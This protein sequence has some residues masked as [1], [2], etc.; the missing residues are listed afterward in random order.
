MG[1]EVI[2]VETVGVGQDEVEIVNT[3]HTSIVVLVPGMGDD[4]QAIKAGIIEIGDLF[5]INKSDREGERKRWER[6]SGRLLMGK[7]RE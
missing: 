1:K 7:Q 2:L 3:A 6:I 5:V 4:I